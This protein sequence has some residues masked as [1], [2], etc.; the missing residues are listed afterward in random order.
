M[1]QIYKSKSTNSKSPIWRFV[2]YG[3]FAYRYKNAQI[4]DVA[5]GK[6]DNAEVDFIASKADDKLYVQ[7]TESMKS[8]DVRARELRP[9]Q[10][11]RDNY[12]KIIL[13]LDTGL[14][15]SYDGI[16]S[17]NLVEWLLSDKQW[18]LSILIFNANTFSTNLFWIADYWQCAFDTKRVLCN[19]GSKKVY[20]YVFNHRG[21]LLFDR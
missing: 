14:N 17:L 7:V 4:Y 3:I 8:E 1:L 18:F 9:L 19:T 10:A 12:E 11:I 15:N 5:I 16:K 2:G 6:V 21:K 13:T 20:Q